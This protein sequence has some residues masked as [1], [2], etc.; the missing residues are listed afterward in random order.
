[1]IEPLLG[2]IAVCLAAGHVY[3]VILARRVR[4]LELHLDHEVTRQL[5]GR[6][7]DML[8]MLDVAHAVDRLMLD[9]YGR[10]IDYHTNRD[11][12]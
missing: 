8:L 9:H 1:M 2:L 12:N 11:L 5:E 10:G 3:S 4:A 6:R 7:E